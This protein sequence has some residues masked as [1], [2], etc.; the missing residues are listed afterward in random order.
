MKEMNESF[1]TFPKGNFKVFKVNET[2][3]KDKEQILLTNDL[4]MRKNY[5]KWNGFSIISSHSSKLYFN[6]FG[7]NKEQL[8]QYSS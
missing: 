2:L 8:F 4:A 1:L 7:F 3:L 6:S 5:S